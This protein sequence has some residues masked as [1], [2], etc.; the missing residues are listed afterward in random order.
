MAVFITGVAGFVGCN[1]ARA[2]L[3][4]G[5]QVAGFDNLCRGS[6]ANLEPIRRQ[7]R[8]AFERVDLDDLDAYRRA[9]RALHAR[10]PITEVWHLAANSD[11]PAG[12]TDPNV[13]LRDT[14]MTTFNTLLLMKELRIATLAFASSSAV[15][16]DHGG[17]KLTEDEGPLLP[18]SNYGAMKLASEAAVSA[19]LE[20][21]L[22]RAFVFRFPNVIGVPATHGVILDFVRKLRAA[23]GKLEVLGDGNQQKDY[24][25]V[26]EL[27]DAMLFIRAHARGKL[28][29]FNVGADDEGVSVR[30]IAEA[31]VRRVAPQA[32]ISFGAGPIGWPGDVPR[33]SYSIAKLLRLGWRPKR[34]SA[35]AVCRA[36]DEIAAQEGVGEIAARD[37]AAIAV[38]EGA[39]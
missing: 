19:A 24:L 38:R 7:P 4:R 27:V 34:S 6:A 17:R 33:F 23:P 11:I 37:G 12:T 9:L 32:R 31:V 18:I 13:D 3:E 39:A 2:M 26:D 35:Q 36:V 15:F 10:S 16:G 8:F 29:C 5:E 14:F 1:L 22:E 20:S 21:H 30:L 28:N 25:H